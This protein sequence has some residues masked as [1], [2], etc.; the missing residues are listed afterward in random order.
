VIAAFVEL[1]RREVR[2]GRLPAVDV[3]PT[4]R[5]LVGM[6]LYCFFNRIVGNPAADTDAIV[7]T[8]LTVWARTFMLSDPQPGPGRTGR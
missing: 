6:N 4:V 8:L 1:T 3:E 5:A 7:E 2:A